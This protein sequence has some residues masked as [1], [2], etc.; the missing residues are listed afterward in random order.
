MTVGAVTARS[1]GWSPANIPRAPRSATV[2]PLRPTRVLKTRIPP[3]ISLRV[4]TTAAQRS[5][6][7]KIAKIAVGTVFRSTPLTLFASEAVWY[8]YNQVVEPAGFPGFDAIT[9]GWRSP[10][11]TG[12]IGSYAPNSFDH[13][14]FNN[15]PESLLDTNDIVAFTIRYWGDFGTNPYPNPV[16]GLNWPTQPVQL[17]LP[18]PM[19]APFPPPAPVPRQKPEYRPRYNSLEDLSPRLRPRPRWRPARNMQITINLRP[20][21]SRRPGQAVVFRSDVPRVRNDDL[22]AAPASQFVYDVLKS[23]ANAMGEVKEWIDILADAAGWKPNPKLKLFGA[24]HVTADKAIWLFA[25]HG[26][27]N[28]DFE[29]LAVL[30]VENEIEDRLFAVA[31]KLSKSAARS[32]NL[33]IGPQ[34]GPALG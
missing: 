17:P 6:L 9:A 18:L 7:S 21:P 1:T 12:E 31:G 11:Y 24:G 8:L 25:Q 27:N 2:T 16:P 4:A 34:T 13:G 10:V 20:G 15:P 28:I 19:P 3:S 23:L 22:K 33:T 29:R 30:I 5:A 14:A 26:L 32:L